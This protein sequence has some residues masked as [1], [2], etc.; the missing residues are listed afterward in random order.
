MHVYTPLYRCPWKQKKV[1]SPLKLELQLVV[2]YLACVQACEFE[3]S[4]NAVITLNYLAI[5]SASVFMF[6]FNKSLVI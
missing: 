6:F 5:S 1:S 2:S 4:R 3:S